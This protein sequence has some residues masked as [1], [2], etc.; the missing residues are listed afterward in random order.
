MLDIE[1]ISFKYNAARVLDDVSFHAGKGECIGIIGPNGSGKSTLLKT[2]SK[3]LK[4]DAGRVVLG[5]RGLEEYSTRELARNMAVVPQDTGIDFDFTCLEVVLMGR[6]PHMRRFEIEGRKDTDI[7]L[8]AM[9]LTSTGHLRDRP[10]AE[11]SGGE[12]QRVIIARALAQQPSVLLLDEPVSH[13]DINHQIEILDLVSRL[14]AER[15]LVVIVILH[16][17]NLA[18][19]YC[20]RLLLLSESRILAAGPPDAVLTREY[21]GAAFHANVLVKKHPVTGYLYVTPL[22]GP[23]APAPPN[24]RTVH[25]VCG[26]GTGTPLMYLLRSHGYGV[27]TGA[28][29]VLD[30]DYEAAVQLGI[31]AVGEAPFSPITPEA[32]ARVV[33]MMRKAD[34]VVVSDVPF[35][36][37]NLKNL[38][39]VLEAGRPAILVKNG[40]QGDY[41][42]GGATRL[43]EKLRGRGALTATADAHLLELLDIAA[44]V[45]NGESQ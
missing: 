8:E 5:G 43:M 44:D 13:L 2:L 36:W 12:R 7:A 6:S 21:I 33:A 15:G 40:E 32:Y 19:R 31:P 1:G 26:A 22:N 35:G 24:G 34:A 3:I 45:K 39:A 4:P 28:L 16:D 41:T 42:N 17:L 25:L 18:A 11:L 27:T 23:E 14:K 38:E 37:G 10:F 30:S 20:D 9:L 29:N